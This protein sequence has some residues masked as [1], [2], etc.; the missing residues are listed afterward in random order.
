[1]GGVGPP[2]PGRRG[3]R[4]PLITVSPGFAAFAPARGSHG[5][6]ERGD[7]VVGFA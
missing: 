2:S 7:W 6:P 1:M 4:G 3:G 5:T